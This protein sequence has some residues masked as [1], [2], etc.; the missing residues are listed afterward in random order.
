MSYVN[1][2]PKWTAFVLGELESQEQDAARKLL[3]RDPAMI[4][5]VEQLREISALIQE[6][7]EGLSSIELTDD[8]RQSIL[9]AAPI[10]KKIRWRP[11]LVASAAV[12][13]LTAGL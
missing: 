2:D 1:D 12:L 9:S 3:E 10:R 6:S 4:E 11:L 13:I 7:L 8:Q 5:R